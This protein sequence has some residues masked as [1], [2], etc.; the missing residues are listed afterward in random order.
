MANQ[1][2]RQQ[3]QARNLVSA[4]SAATEAKPTAVNDASSDRSTERAG[5]TE[6]AA[7]WEW[8][9]CAIV[10]ILFASAT[11]REHHILAA[12]EP[13]DFP[14]AKLLKTSGPLRNR[15]FLVYYVAGRVALGEGDSRLYYP[16]PG[17]KAEQN[18]VL[19]ER[20]VPVDTA[21]SRV[22]E[23]SIGATTTW[24]YI[25]PPFFAWL[26]SPIARMP[27]M[28]AYVLWLGLST[29][30]LLLSIYLVLRSV[31]PTSIPLAFLVATVGV[32]CFFPSAESLWQGQANCLIL[33]LWT[34][35]FY[36]ARTKRTSLS[37]VC[38][39]LNTFVKMTPAIVIPILLLR[40]QWKW[41]ISYSVSA[42]GLLAVSIWR[43][44][45]EAHWVYLSRML[46]ALSAGIGGYRQRSLAAE[47]RNLYWR[48]A[49][50]TQYDSLAIPVDLN[51]LVKIICIALYAGVLFYF[52]KKKRKGEVALSEELAIAALIS[53]I[54]SPVAWRH[55]F[56]LSLL[57]LIYCWMQS[58]DDRSKARLC[59]LALLT[60]AL[61]TP[62]A[63]FVLLRAHNGLLQAV[64]ASAFL[65]ASCILLFLCLRDYG[66]LQPIPSPGDDNIRL[67]TARGRPRPPRAE[68]LRRQP[69]SSWSGH[70]GRMEASCQNRLT[71]N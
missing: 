61:G 35:G 37:A 6:R 23:R 53:L 65:L 57:P 4:N 62:L 56:V 25:Y 54:I 22:A 12:P 16:A 7:A 60:I 48:H 9:I 30:W 42:A 29:I 11:A 13:W 8:S 33:F 64:L 38:F 34:A 68:P 70:F 67:F 3:L 19:L 43:M 27:P 71:R 66:R 21:W 55:H 58:R 63:D 5:N 40:R 24:H 41:L 1:F 2:N 14:T 39:A 20:I 50:L 32:L 69:L 36:C 18:S 46:P 59:A 45:W 51:V 17:S 44:G 52:W 15:D 49:T 10:L 26:I 28:R 31:Q 47:V